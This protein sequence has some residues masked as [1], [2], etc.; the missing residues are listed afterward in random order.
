MHDPSRTLAK[1]FERYP[2]PSVQEFLEAS[3]FDRAD[4][5]PVRWAADFLQREV[6]PND[7][8]EVEIALY[9]ISPIGFAY[10]FPIWIG[11]TLNG[12]WGAGCNIYSANAYVLQAAN[13]D[14]LSG[15]MTG[16]YNKAQI[17]SLAAAM[18]AA[19]QCVH[20][21]DVAALMKARAKSL[22]AS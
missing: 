1:A 22:P 20:F 10:L 7:A 12:N 2:R 9:V 8:N 19:A 3:A 15:A 11:E 4:S 17:A 18:R 6:R 14:R 13:W 21:E 5:E 16:R